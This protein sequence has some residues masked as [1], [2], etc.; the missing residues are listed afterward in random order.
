MEQLHELQVGGVA[1]EV[2]LDD[3]VDAALDEDVVIAGDEAHLCEY[4]EAFVL[5]Q[6]R[7]VVVAGDE[8]HLN[9]PKLVLVLRQESSVMH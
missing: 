5:R 9:K 2:V 6:E 4:K 3:A 7:F 1:A 8:A